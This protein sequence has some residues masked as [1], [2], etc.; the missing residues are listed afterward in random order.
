M[1]YN[2]PWQ[3]ESKRAGKS[4]Y[5][6]NSSHPDFAARLRV[7]T[8]THDEKRNGV[9]VVVC[10]RELWDMLKEHGL[11]SRIE[12][13]SIILFPGPDKPW[14]ALRPCVTP[15]Y[16]TVRPPHIPEE[17]TWEFFDN[18]WKGLEKLG[19]V[20]GLVLDTTNKPPATYEWE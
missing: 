1:K 10:S 15:D 19:E 4:Y 16:M 6:E 2:K 11:Y 20:D 8:V 14:V 17:M 18:A 3:L 5:K 9:Y 12:Q 7:N 13:M